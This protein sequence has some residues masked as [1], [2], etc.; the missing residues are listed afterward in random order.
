MNRTSFYAEIVA[1]TTT[2]VTV[3]QVMVVTINLSK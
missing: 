1:D 3:N 2:H